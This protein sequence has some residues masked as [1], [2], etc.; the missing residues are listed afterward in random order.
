MF[1]T[2]RE[3]FHQLSEC[4]RSALVNQTLNEIE[5]MERMGGREL[6]RYVPSRLVMGFD[7]YRGESVK[8]CYGISYN[9]LRR[10][11]HEQTKHATD[12]LED[13]INSN[14]AAA[15]TIDEIVL[16]ITS[17][18]VI[19]GTILGTNGMGHV[20]TINARLLWN[21]RYGSNSKNGVLTVYPQFRGKRSGALALGESK[22]P[23]EVPA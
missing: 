12:L 19:E 20:F 21:Y 9:E 13:R 11:T 14:L 6:R 17:E 18:N 5:R 15:D 4:I 7:P 8:A 22:R 2:P 16:R 23:A 3:L 10:L 1:R